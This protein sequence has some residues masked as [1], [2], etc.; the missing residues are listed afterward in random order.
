MSHPSLATC[1]L[2]STGGTIAMKVDPV[3]QAPVPALSGD[4]LL[5]L[6]PEIAEY[7]NLKVNNLANTPSSYMGPDQWIELQGAVTRE[8]E[9]PD[10]AGVVVT[11]GT[12]T[13]EET[14][15]FL[16]LTVSS[17]KPVVLI[18]AQ[19]NASEP[20]FDGPRNLLNAVKVCVCPEARDLGA[21]VVLNSQIN[22]ARDVAKTHTAHVEAFQS[23]TFGLLGEV[24]DDRIVI[25]RRPVK[26]QFLP[27]TAS[28]LPRVDIV[29]MYAGADGCLIRAAVAAGA[30]GIVVQGLG[31]GNV[32]LEIYE[33]IVEA[34]ADGV[35]VLMST[36]VQQGRVRPHYGFVGGGKTLAE[37]GVLFGDDLS[38]QK[39]R[40]LL[41]L[42]LQSVTD[43]A[44]IQD[45]FN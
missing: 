24:W 22:A 10:V 17:S 31:L 16:D 11:H 20:D 5:A 4:E 27:L 19:R 8:L 6:V 39:A 12:D 30:K 13:L 40:I 25:A 42:A 15:W 3:K 14:A 33:A 28:T 43:P 18:G 37:A 7:A 45:L 21:M 41:M 36:R 35:Q 23:G 2:I 29:S 9:K 1:C 26:R 44:Q 34:I 38:P 32:N